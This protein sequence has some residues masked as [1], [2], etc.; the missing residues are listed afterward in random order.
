[1]PTLHEELAMAESLNVDALAEAIVDIGFECTQCGACCTAEENAPHTAIIFP[2][3][4]RDLKTAERDWE[5]IARP[6]PFGFETGADT[7]E[8]ALQVDDCGD[9]TFYAD[10]ECSVYEQRPL[11]C[12]TYPFDID[13]EHDDQRISH[14]HLYASECPG[15]ENDIS[16]EDA[17][18]LAK[19]IKQRAITDRRESLAVQEQYSTNPHTTDEPAV[20]DSEGLKHPD[21]RIFEP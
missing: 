4:V 16:R 21:G 11:I 20:Y 13:F 17:R 14:D 15:L 12:Q 18:K 3:E 9:C 6:M 1:M 8:W 5:D 2:D 7:L 10:G 19:Q